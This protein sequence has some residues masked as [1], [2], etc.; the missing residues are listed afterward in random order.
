ME[1]LGQSQRTSLAKTIPIRAATAEGPV[2][3]N[4]EYVNRRLRQYRS[5]FMVSSKRMMASNLYEKIWKSD[6]QSAGLK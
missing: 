4:R 6:D 5:D 3:P 1:G 2:D